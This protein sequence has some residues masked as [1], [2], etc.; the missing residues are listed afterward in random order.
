MQAEQL[1]V[2][3]AGELLVRVNETS[4]SAGSVTAVH[5]QRGSEAL[6]VLA[7]ES[8]TCSADGHLPNGTGHGIKESRTAAVRGDLGMDVAANKRRWPCTTETDIQSPC[9]SKASVRRRW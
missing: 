1:P 5:A 6:Y 4:G 9:A 2:V 7:G 3:K 8:G